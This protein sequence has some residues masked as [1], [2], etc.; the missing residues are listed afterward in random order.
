MYRN[1]CP[2]A[3]ICRLAATPAGLLIP[4]GRVTATAL[5]LVDDTA[6]LPES[7]GFAEVLPTMIRNVPAGVVQPLF[8]YARSR[9]VSGNVTVWLAPGGNTTRRN[10]LSCLGGSPAELGKPTYS[11]A[12]SAPARLPVFVTV[13]DTLAVP[14]ALH[15]EICRFEKEKLV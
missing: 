2:D 9:L 8:Q 13:A 1:D 12:I 15:D 6:R 3:W 7:C 14:A 4:T 10:P 5:T 11:W